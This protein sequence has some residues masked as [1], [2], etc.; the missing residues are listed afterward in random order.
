MADDP[1]TIRDALAIACE[2]S[3]R[4][5]PSPEEEAKLAEW[6]R[7][8]VEGYVNA[9]PIARWELLHRGLDARHEIEGVAELLGDLS[10]T[11]LS[12]DVQG[13][14]RVD[15]LVAAL[16]EICGLVQRLEQEGPAVRAAQRFVEGTSKRVSDDIAETEPLTP[17]GNDALRRAW[18]AERDRLA[19]LLVMAVMTGHGRDVETSREQLTRG[20]QENAD[21]DYRTIAGKRLDALVALIPE[22]PEADLRLFRRRAQERRSGQ[23]PDDA[24]RA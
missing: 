10:N 8:K 22:T 7:E 6:A 19:D 21:P 17:E 23:G 14:A 16:D 9:Y 24:S 15:V 5:R 3:G 4:P 11:T 13:T 18:I 12:P 20:L 1:P 2:I